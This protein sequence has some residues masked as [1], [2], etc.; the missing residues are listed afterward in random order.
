VPIDREGTGEENGLKRCTHSITGPIDREGIGEENGLKRY[1]HSSWPL[2]FSSYF[3]TFNNQQNTTIIAAILCP[4]ACTTGVINKAGIVI[5]GESM[6]TPRAKLFLSFIV[7]QRT[8]TAAPWGF[9]N[10]NPKKDSFSLS[11]DRTTK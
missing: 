6:K 4:S 10:G 3:L 11:I 8:N 1:T 2:D 9:R 5:C 7:Q